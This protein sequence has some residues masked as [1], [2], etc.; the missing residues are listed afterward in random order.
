M[1]SIG[2]RGGDHRRTRIDGTQPSNYRSQEVDPRYSHPS[3]RPTNVESR[4]RRRVWLRFS[5]S[6]SYS[7]FRSRRGGL[8][9]GGSDD[10]NV[11]SGVFSR[12]EAEISKEESEE[13]EIERGSS[14][15]LEAGEDGE[16]AG[17][18]GMSDTHSP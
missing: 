14:V 9:C 16:G 10:E 4:Q 7:I 5:S 17:S 11:R 13:G 12:G 2:Q 8:G 18:I 15:K 1:R 6:P 3:L